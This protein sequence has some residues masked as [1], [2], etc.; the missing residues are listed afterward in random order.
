[1]F[2]IK[3]IDDD[4]RKEVV[5]LA[6]E[7]WSSSIIVSKGKVHSFEDL[8]GFIA[9]ENCRIIGIITYSITD[10]SCEIA[11]LDSLVENRGV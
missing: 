4:Y 11:S 6:I 1:M 10:D 5:K 7:N 3:Q 8:P 9:L 2:L